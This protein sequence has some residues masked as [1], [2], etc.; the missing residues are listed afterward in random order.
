MAESDSISLYGTGVSLQGAPTNYSNAIFRAGAVRGRNAAA[1][2]GSKKTPLIKPED[3][4]TMTDNL[5]PVYNTQATQVLQRYANDF[6]EKQREYGGDAT[7]AA[8]AMALEEWKYRSEL[9]NINANNAN[10]KNYLALPGDKF[11]VNDPHRQRV[12]EMAFNP[13]TTPEQWAQGVTDPDN[14]ITGGIDYSLNVPVIPKMDVN[15]IIPQY[16]KNTKLVPGQFV[17]IGNGLQRAI[18]KVE[19]VDEDKD[20][21][22]HRV[23]SDPVLWA[24]FRADNADWLKQNYPEAYK[25]SPKDTAVAS[26]QMY[27]AAKAR[28]NS[29]FPVLEKPETR[30]IPRPVVTPEAKAA[31][32]AKAKGWRAS[33]NTYQNDQNIWHYDRDPQGRETFTFSKVNPA[34]NS[35]M[36]FKSVNAEGKEESVIGIPVRF[37]MAPGDKFPMLFISIKDGEEEKAVIYNPYNAAKIK[38]EYGTDPFT[39][40]A[41]VTGTA[42]EGEGAAAGVVTKT[43]QQSNKVEKA[44]TIAKK[45]YSASRNQTRIIY[46]DGTEEIID[47]RN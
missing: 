36:S 18:N 34:D 9:N 15:A 33:G 25:L 17:P 22:A 24:N 28:L 38:N 31:S 5:L 46:S 7:K 23:A 32:A 3:F 39:V 47:G 40:R 19:V 29:L 37:E 16:S 21:A 1:Y 26:E 35:K 2:A 42:K 20:A 6:L 27:Q 43:K 14:A 10:T 13:G 8:N 4:K 45:Q 41:Q 44:K 30:S 12:R 11:L